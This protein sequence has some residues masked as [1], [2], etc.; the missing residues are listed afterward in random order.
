MSNIAGESYDVVIAGAGPAGSS[1]AIRLSNA[2]KRV[3]LVEKA[4]FP[5]EKL[6]GEFISP[7]CIRHFRELDVMNRINLAGGAEIDTTT[8]YSRRGTSFS[9]KSEWFRLA[10]SGA[11]G[12]S[13]AELDRI[14]LD[15]A[16]ESGADVILGTNVTG[17][18]QKGDTVTGIVIKNDDGREKT[19]EA[20]LTVDATGRTRSLARRI[21]HSATP[22]SSPAS[23][24]FKS[25]LKGAEPAAN[26]CEIYSYSGGYG[27]CSRVEKDLTNICFIVSSEHVKRIGSNAEQV[28]REVLCTNRRAADVIK[29]AVV[30]KPWLAVPISNYG[31]RSIVPARGMLAV[32]DAAA[33]IDPFTGSGILLALESGRIAADA[34]VKSRSAD[35]LESNFRNEYSKAFDS[36]LRFCSWLRYAAFVPFLTDTAIRTLAFSNS[37]TRLVARSTRSSEGSVA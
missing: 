13:R 2:G 7:E 34:I 32:G 27:G 3:L 26:T 21:E 31:R 20:E 9:V 24:A 12:L 6:C 36:R 22:K 33:F 19:V 37:L 35:S 15:R 16:N 1:L 30:A 10:G 8:F 25:H 23:V 29:N 11:L 28:M 18:V 14:L 5:R 17:L 4:R